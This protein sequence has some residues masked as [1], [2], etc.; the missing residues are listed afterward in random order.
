MTFTSRYCTRPKKAKSFF[1]LITR[2]FCTT[3]TSMAGLFLK[4]L[5][6]RI[7]KEIHTAPDRV[8]LAMNNFLI[9]AGCFVTALTDDVL[10]TA[11]RIGKVEVNMG[12]TACKV[13]DATA[14]IMKVKSKGYLGKKKK[15]ARC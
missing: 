7:E 13:P 3:P 14:Y 15:M 5:L 4:K 12:D 10:A 9:A 8:R 1:K 2:N 6:R 11:K